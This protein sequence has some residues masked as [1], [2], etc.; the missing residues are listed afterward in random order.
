LRSSGVIE[1]LLNRSDLG[2]ETS[3]EGAQ[4]AA[5]DVGESGKIVLGQLAQAS[6]EVLEAAFKLGGGGPE[7]RGALIRGRRDRATR[8]G[9][10]GFPG[11]RIGSGAIGRQERERLPG[12]ERM[13][14]DGL[15]QAHLIPESKG[16]QGQG[17][18]ERQPAGVQ[19]GTE[20][21]RQTPG[22]REATPDPG[23]LPAEQLS[24]G[25]EREA[26][27]FHERGHD[28]RLV[29]GTDRA[30]GGVGLE[31]PGLEGDAFRSLDDDGDFHVAVVL[32]E[33]E[34]LE[35]VEDFEGAVRESGHAQ[36]ERR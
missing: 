10:K 32:P 4:H 7:R 26:V 13:A 33:E 3:L 8:V 25:R 22:E 12:T 24:G 20:F 11:R 23:L 1:I 36:G 34:A 15:G 29:H 17:R 35:P 18:G 5:L 14:A 6:F 2:H 21:G 16:A 28:A 9:E 19:P 31:Q 30:S 27:L